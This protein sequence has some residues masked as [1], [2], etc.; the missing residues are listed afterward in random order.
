MVNQEYRTDTAANA[1][2]GEAPYGFKKEVSLFEIVSVLLRQRLVFLRTLLLIAGITFLVAI[3]RPPRYTSSVS[4]VPETSDP[5]AANVFALAQQFGISLGSGSN[6]RTPEFY[7]ALVA[8]GEILRQTVVRRHPVRGAEGE[9]GEIDLI[10][11]Y[12]VDEETEIMRIERAMEELIQDDLEVTTDRDAGIVSF[13]ITTT[14]PSL[15]H[16]VA[17]HILELVNDFDL[18]TRQSQAGS[19]RLFTGERLA[20]QGEELRQAEDTLQG[21]S[22]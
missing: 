2:M 14:Y 4:F 5:E 13:S 8:S 10:E 9:P 16:G 15:S 1:G 22:H 21:F 17:A 6:E 19:E 7:Q 20:Q 3:T 12:E 18:N 11:Y